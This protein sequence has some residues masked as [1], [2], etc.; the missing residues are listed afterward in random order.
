MWRHQLLRDVTNQNLSFI[1]PNK[2]QKPT[3]KKPKLL[4]Q[5]LQTLVICIFS[6]K[7]NS[8]IN[9]KNADVD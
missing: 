4:F 2:T 5:E 1:A 7:S 6:F 8:F 3:P 9:Q